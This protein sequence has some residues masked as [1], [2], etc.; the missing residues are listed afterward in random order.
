MERRY[1]REALLFG[2][3]GVHKLQDKNV[4]VFGLGGVGGALSEALVRAGIGEITLIDGDRVDETNLNRQI[5]ATEKT[6]GEVKTSAMAARLKEINSN[7]II[8]EIPLFYLPEYA[9]SI[10][11]SEFSYVADA[12]DTVTAKL[13]IIEEAKKCNVPVISAM[14]AGN[15]L[16]PTAFEVADISKTAVCP[17]A[18]VMRRELKLKGIT[19]V[20]T[21]F[22]K[23]PPAEAPD[24]SGTVGSVSFV[25][26]VMGYI[27]AG[28]IIKDLI[29][30]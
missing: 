26:P 30:E 23:E 16:D 19:G 25:P 3:A 12:V 9:E 28:E 22:S 21:V 4:A 18:K 27:M 7:L 13:S 20:K 24:A 15:K 6:V 10:D 14:G 1:A 11:F 29:K 2:E 17:L 5:I 8:H